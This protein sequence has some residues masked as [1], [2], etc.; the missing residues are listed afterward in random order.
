MQEFDYLVVGGGS[1]GVATARRAAEYGAKVALVEGARLGG[2]CVN[3]GC[4][5][6]K[7]MWYA[8]SFAHGLDRAAGLG[9]DVRKEGFDWPTLKRNRDA[10][11][12]RLNGIYGTML[13][14]SGVTQLHGWGRLVEAGVVEV[15]GTRYRARHIVIAP[16]GKPD[17][18]PVPGAELGITSD[19]FF[20]LE[21]LPKRVAIV[22]AGYIAVELAGVLRALGAEV[23]M[24]IRGPQVLRPFDAM[25]REGLMEIMSAEGIVLRTKT[26]AKAVHKNADGSLKIDLDSGEALEVDTLIWAT[27]RTPNTAE[28]GL[29]AAGVECRQDGSVVVDAFQNTN[30]AGI[31]ALGDITGQAELTPVAIAAGRALAARL[32]LGE[33][34][35]KLAPRHVPSVIFTHPPIGTVGMTEEDARRIHASV[36]VYTTRFTSMYYALAEHRVPTRMKLVCAGADEVVVGLHILGEGADEILQ[37]FA[38]ALELGATKRDFDRTLAIH[39]TS[40]EELVTMR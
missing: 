11:I 30:V 39:P 37:G 8:A 4:V 31:Y 34:D 35:S 33:R 2:T 19:G 3:V 24:L 16:G 18:P 13:E 12:Q 5:P 28:L 26:Q 38:V 7:V 25:L 14:K 1:G 22:G 20:E 9:F 36:R 17:V 6:K 15:D 32:F 40:G 10:Y 29:D 21:D 23:T 27:G